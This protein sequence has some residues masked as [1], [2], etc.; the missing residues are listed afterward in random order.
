VVD[1]LA[2]NIRIVDSHARLKIAVRAVELVGAR[3]WIQFSDSSRA[4]GELVLEESAKNRR[5]LAHKFTFE[6]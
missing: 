3:P 4:D 5:Y 6:P 2:Q 1:A